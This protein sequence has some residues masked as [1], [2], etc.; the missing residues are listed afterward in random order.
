MI[1]LFRPLPRMKGCMWMAYHLTV[2]TIIVLMSKKT[3]KTNDSVLDS[4]LTMTV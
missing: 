4:V 1:D 3:S 2:H